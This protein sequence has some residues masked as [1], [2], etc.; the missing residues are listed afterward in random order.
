M[1]ISLRNAKQTSKDPHA[2]GGFKSHCACYTCYNPRFICN[3]GKEEEC[4]FADLV[5][6]ICWAKFQNRNW[7]AQSLDELGGGHVKTDEAKYMLWLG[8]QQEVFGAAKASRACVVAAFAF[9]QLDQG[10]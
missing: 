7:V 1:I 3:K 5:M 4:E 9:R 6:P 2:G 8:E 10:T